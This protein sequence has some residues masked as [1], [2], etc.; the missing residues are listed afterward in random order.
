MMHKNMKCKLDKKRL[1]DGYVVQSTTQKFSF[2][3]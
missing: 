1:E 2:P 3:S